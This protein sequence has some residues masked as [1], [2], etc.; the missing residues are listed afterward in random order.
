MSA[1]M[2][3]AQ[4][5]ANGMPRLIQA[6][7]ALIRSGREGRLGQL[8]R[9]PLLPALALAATLAGCATPLYD[10]GGYDTGLHNAQKDPTQVGATREQLQTHI[11]KLEASRQRVAPGLYAD[12]GTMYLEANDPD[13]AIVY[14]EKERAAWPEST[15]LMTAM[16]DNLRRRQAARANTTGAKP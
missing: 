9:R 13:R 1:T 16:I 10:W 15:V 11:G 5:M 14:Y 7:R 8:A 6:G 12:L 4:F 2:T 3:E